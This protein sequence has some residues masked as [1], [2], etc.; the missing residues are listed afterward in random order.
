MLGLY[1]A[2]CAE[3][4]AKLMPYIAEI[5]LYIAMFTGYFATFAVYIAMFAGYVAMTSMYF[6]MSGIS[7]P[8]SAVCVAMSM[9]F[10]A[11]AELAGSLTMISGA[12]FQ[13]SGPVNQGIATFV[14]A[15]VA[16]IPVMEPHIVGSGTLVTAYGQDGAQITRSFPPST[17]ICA[18]VVFAKSGPHSSAAS[19]ATSRLVT[20]TPR[21]LLLR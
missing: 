21:T 1:I 15:N 19:S 11:K 14:P 16:L 4:V 3:Y 17:G 5:P 8:V 12:L 13:L 10:V 20:S 6:A 2:E 7:A 18:P 9:I